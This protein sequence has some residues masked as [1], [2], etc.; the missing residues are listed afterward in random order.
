MTTVSTRS[1]TGART[2]RITTAKIA[3]SIKALLHSSSSCGSVRNVCRSLRTGR[4][5]MSAAEMPKEYK[6]ELIP[7]IEVVWEEV[8]GLYRF[9]GIDVKEE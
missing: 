5:Q 1:K 3:A 7:G 2:Q 9:V 6:E 4:K 8:D